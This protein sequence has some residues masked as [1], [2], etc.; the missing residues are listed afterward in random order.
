MDIEK[1][2]EIL[3]EECLQKIEDFKKKHEKR[4][5]W[6]P[7]EKELYWYIDGNLNVCSLIFWGNITN[8]YIFKAKNCFKTKEE[9]ERKA[10]E[11]KLHRE[12]EIF[13][14]ENDV[15]SL[16]GVWT[17]YYDRK[18]NKL[19]SLPDEQNYCFG[20]ISFSCKE[21][22]DKAIEIFK[23]DLIRYYTSGK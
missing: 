11:I 10:F 18:Q 19:I 22:T 4:K 23:D 20:A 5:I 17:I 3:K 2:L 1:E 12:L 13:A 14:Y 7:K 16:D 15:I 9:A 8:E 6:I 21:V